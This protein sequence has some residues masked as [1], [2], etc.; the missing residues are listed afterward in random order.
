LKHELISLRVGLVKQRGIIR[1]TG[2]KNL[3]DSLENIEKQSILFLVLLHLRFFLKL[4]II[5]A[6][7]NEIFENTLIAVGE[8]MFNLL[9]VLLLALKFLGFDFKVETI[10]KL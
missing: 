4:E 6:S 5:I 7:E 8:H 3:E 9:L 1:N 2:I 10:D